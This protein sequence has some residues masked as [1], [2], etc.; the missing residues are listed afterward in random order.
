MPEPAKILP[1]SPFIV[2]ARACS[3]AIHRGSCLN[4]GEVC[5]PQQDGFRT[6]ISREGDEPCPEG[7]GE[8]HVFHADVDDQRFCEPCS[9]SAPSGGSCEVRFGLFTDSACTAQILAVNLFSGM[10]EKCH[11][12]APGIALGSKSAELIA[13]APGS[14]MPSGGGPS[15][16]V[17]LSEPVTFCC[18]EVP[19]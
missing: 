9:C 13:Y 8:R 5:V 3:S 16:E 6:C 1:D 11:D 14:C 2:S 17:V 19:T 10:G 12:L 15:G 7:W 4:E 18:R